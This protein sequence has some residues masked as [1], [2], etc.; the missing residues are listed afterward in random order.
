MG[1]LPGVVPRRLIHAEVPEQAP[2]EG[3]PTSHVEGSLPSQG[4]DHQTA[5]GQGE[6]DT[7]VVS[8]R[9][10]EGGVIKVNR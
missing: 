4:V 7:D 8:C 5:E 9:R 10:G 3:E 2:G 1:S 6:R